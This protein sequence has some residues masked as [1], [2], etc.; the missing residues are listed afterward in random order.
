MVGL[1]G[2]RLACLA[3]PA[4]VVF[5]FEFLF[6]RMNYHTSCAGVGEIFA[7]H[8]HQPGGSEQIRHM[9]RHFVVHEHA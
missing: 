6:T 1:R 3:N 8:F 4:A 5:G 9:V 7:G 2:R